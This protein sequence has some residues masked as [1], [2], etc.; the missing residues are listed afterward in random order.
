VNNC[1]GS[2]NI[3]FFLLF[4]F[5]TF[6]G[7]AYAATIAIWRIAICWRG[8]C[9]IPALPVIVLG[10]FSTVMA[11]FFAIFVVAMMWDQYT[12]VT[13]D[14]TA[15]EAM[16]G[17]EETP[18]SLRAGLE[19]AFGE[20]FGWRWF[21]PVRMPESSP[22]FYRW[23][24]TDDVDAYDPRDP[25]VIRHLESVR[26]RIRSAKRAANGGVSEAA[27]RVGAAPTAARPAYSEGEDGESSEGESGEESES[28][29]EYEGDGEEDAAASKKQQQQ[30]QRPQQQGKAAAAAAAAKPVLSLKSDGMRKRN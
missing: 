14:T 6:L 2:N 12:G 20:P 10:V 29:G 16:K 27:A 21:F 22:S 15:I 25:L 17:W 1:V 13:T 24:K 18:R 28:E 5:W 23:K 11:I 4:L 8:R 30:Q 19:D 7:S 3:K 26:S 9:V